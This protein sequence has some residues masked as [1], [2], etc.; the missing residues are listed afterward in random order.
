MYVSKH[1]S[2]C[3]W[4]CWRRAKNEYAWDNENGR[5]CTNNSKTEKLFRILDSLRECDPDWV[6]NTTNYHPEYG[7]SFKSG[8]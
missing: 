3:E 7:S 2:V 4:D 6:I 5:L 8:Y 1:W